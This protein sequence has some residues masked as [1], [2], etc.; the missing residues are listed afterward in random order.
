MSRPIGVWIEVPQPASSRFPTRAVRLTIASEPEP[1]QCTRPPAQYIA[2]KTAAAP[3]VSA[4]GAM[5]RR[6]SSMAPA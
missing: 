4:A 1:A 3:R 5:S 2:A 6:R